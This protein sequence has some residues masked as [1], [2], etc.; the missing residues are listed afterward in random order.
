[1]LATNQTTDKTQVDEVVVIEPKAITELKKEAATG[2]AALMKVVVGAAADST[3]TEC[4]K[5]SAVKESA[6]KATSESITPSTDKPEDNT[7]SDDN[8]D[9]DDEEVTK[10]PVFK[11]IRKKEED[12]ELVELEI[13]DSYIINSVQNHVKCEGL[14]S[15]PRTIRSEDLFTILPQLRKAVAHEEPVPEGEEVYCGD[16]KRGLVKLVQFLENEHKVAISTIKNMTDQGKISFK[17]LWHLFSAGAFGVTEVQGQEQG[18]VVEKAIY[19][20][21]CFGGAFFVVTGKSIDCDG[22]NFKYDQQSYYISGFNDVVPIESLSVKPLATDSELFQTLTERGKT[23]E[24]YAVGNTYLSYTDRM[25]RQGWFAP[26][27]FKAVGRIMVDCASFSQMNPNYNMGAASGR[28]GRNRYLGN[29]ISEAQKMLKVP[30]NMY[31]M[32]SPTLYGFSFVAKRWGQL[33]VKYITE[34]QY[35]EHAFERLVLDPERKKLI[36]NLVNSG[37]SSNLDLINGK[38]N[39]MIFLLHGTPGVGKTLT[40]ESVAEHLHRPLYSVSAGE[41]GTDVVSLERKL[42]EILEVASVWSA[43]ILIDEADIFLEG[44]SENDIHRNALVGIFLRLLEY[45]QGILFLTTNR[46]QCFDSAFKSR[47]TLALKYNDLDATARSQIWTTFLDRSEGV[48]NWN[49][50]VNELSQ[51]AINGREIKN[52]VRL[53]KAMAGSSVDPI[54]MENVRK[55]LLMMRN[56]DEEVEEEVNNHNKRQKV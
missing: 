5:E 48:G 45:H 56:F 13:Q 40:G 28:T 22:A 14:Y 51:A 16:N 23:F 15:D 41:L 12:T 53:A 17:Y 42:S 9:N 38:G 11:V 37:T 4:N 27:Y 25:F 49:L 32:C 47:I 46:V 52:V 8:A 39:G 26:T 2:I 30:E 21:S 44:R 10:T 3:A 54:T 20:R 24:K 1:M 50:D 7:K 34:I 6:A 33:F 36:L 19:Q 18:F 43:V 31:F 55:V 35:D 29:D